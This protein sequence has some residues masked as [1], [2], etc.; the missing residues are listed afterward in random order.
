L[1]PFVVGII[2]KESASFI[3]FAVTAGVLILFGTLITLKKP[4]NKEIYT[5]EG[6]ATVTATW[7][8]VSVLGAV[9]YV[10][11]GE[12]PNFAD[13]IFETASG[14]TTTGSTILND[15]ESVSNACL[16]WR[17]FSHWLGGMGVL[18]FILAVVPQNDTRTMHLVR[19]ESPGPTAGKLTSK[20]SFSV[21][22]L[23]GIYIALTALE[24]ILLTC[25]KM[26]FFEALNHAFATAGT[27]GFGM[28]NNSI[29]D[30]DSVYIDVVITVFM[31]LFS[32][33]FTMYYLLLS[34]KFLQ[35]F[36]NEELRLFLAIVFTA[37][38][39][40][41]VNIIPIY[42][43]FFKS[44]RYSSFQVL[45]V[46]ST[47]GFATADFTEWP[48]FSQ[49][50]LLL[51]MFIG[52]CAGSTGG[53]LKVMRILIMFKTAL[54]EIKCVLNPRSVVT[55]K[56]DGKA[57]DKEVIRGVSFYFVV[58]MLLL[59]ISAL[60]LSIDGHDIPTTVTAVITCLNNV[61]PGLGEISPSGNFSGF[62]SWAKILLSL[63]M[64]LG[65]LE[66]YPMLV[67]FTIRKK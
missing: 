9:P 51:L 44:F 23:Y 59:A 38:I 1:L 3:A 5:R 10:L 25:S 35:V 41:A 32:V 33:N 18:V 39:V 29:A 11:S 27:G 55:I 63:D 61:G 26:T 43:N 19:A 21:R 14:F 4:E 37:S 20:M 30:Y 17:S 64:L 52:G 16:F 34:K 58:F 22:I 12:I 8:L 60:L 48:F 45:T 67:L 50:I 7:I 53:G 24:T 57:I 40:I 2:Y 65:R 31:L 28:T 49:M 47:A 42:G 15:I 66:I 6:M 62:S 54:R 36:K 46:I 13:A 56:C